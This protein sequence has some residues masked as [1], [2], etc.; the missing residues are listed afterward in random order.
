MGPWSE[1]NNLLHSNKTIEIFSISLMY[2]SKFLCRNRFKNRNLEHELYI[3]SNT[4]LCRITASKQNLH[5]DLKLEMDVIHPSHLYAVHSHRFTSTTP[6][7]SASFSNHY[8]IKSEPHR[9]PMGQSSW[10]GFES[11][12]W[13]TKSTQFS[14]M[15]R[16]MT[17]EP[18]IPSSNL[19]R[20]LVSQY[21]N[22]RC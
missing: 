5:N 19:G 16:L 4:R 14:T 10:P 15:R 20:P 12:I 6:N 9:I 7:M 17:Q 3:G 21:P 1:Q 13:D 11:S 22:S 8:D 2:H 18:R